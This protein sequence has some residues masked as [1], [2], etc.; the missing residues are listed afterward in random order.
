MF[1]GRFF[2]SITTFAFLF[3][4]VTTVN[5]KPIKLDFYFEIPHFKLNQKPEISTI[6]GNLGT[7]DTINDIQTT[8]SERPTPEVKGS[9]DDP[10]SP[11]PENSITPNLY[12]TGTQELKDYLI[13]EVNIYRESKGLYKVQTNDLTCDFAKVRALEISKDLSHDDF[14]ERIN[15][16][17][18]PYPGYDKATENLVK[19]SDHKKVVSSW[20]LSETHE[21]NLREDTPFVCIEKYGN[22][23][24]LEGWKPYSK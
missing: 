21:N 8:K 20:I 15:S 2:K 9:S 18:L 19:S 7:A 16:S 22:Y 17:S 1:K 13:S 3:F 10:Q 11:L 6:T 24:V 5:A 4:T 23:Y 12:P 14:F